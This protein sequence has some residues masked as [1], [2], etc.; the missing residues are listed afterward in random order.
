MSLWCMWCICF[1][2]E[3]EKT[4]A[5]IK[6]V[7]YVQTVQTKYIQQVTVGKFSACDLTKSVIQHACALH[8]VCVTLGGTIC[9][10]H[11]VCV[12]R[13]RICA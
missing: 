7:G 9:T 11:R 5:K 8:C 2:I 6:V 10:L 3:I 13:A 12:V 4:F 1:N